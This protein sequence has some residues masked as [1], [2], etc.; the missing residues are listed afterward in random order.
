MMKEY[1]IA[2]AKNQ[3]TTIVRDVEQTTAIALTRRG[4][5]V[6][7]LLSIDEYRRLST[8]RVMFWS[9]YQTFQKKVN[10][11]EL[12]IQPEEFT[13]REKSPGREVTL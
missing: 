5:T 7:I 13:G 10:L 4:K 2:Q 3:L 11:A 6:A 1:S 8:P 9:A 12:N